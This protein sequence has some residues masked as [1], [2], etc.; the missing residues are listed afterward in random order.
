MPSQMRAKPNSSSSAKA[1]TPSATP[2]RTRQPMS[3][4]VRPITAMPMLEWI[5]LEMLR[6][7]STADRGT[8]SDL[9]RS[10]NPFC[11]SL[12]R[13]MAT[14]AEENTMVCTMIPGSRNSL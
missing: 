4:P 11:R 10:T 9:K 6:P 8:G 7:T 2:L 13:P 14:M 12:V 5:R 1:S 3:R